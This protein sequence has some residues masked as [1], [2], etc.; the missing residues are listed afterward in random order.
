MVHW[1]LPA[2]VGFVSSSCEIAPEP[3]RSHFTVDCAM[4]GAK[5]VSHS[6]HRISSSQVKSSVSES[7]SSYLPIPSMQTS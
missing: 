5:N 1:Y 3:T 2:R 4:K 7:S 6:C